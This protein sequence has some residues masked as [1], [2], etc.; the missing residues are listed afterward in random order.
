MT[1]QVV[2]GFVDGARAFVRRAIGVEL[3]GSDTSLAFVDHYLEKT[4]TPDLK[5]DVLA[6]VAPALGAYFGEVA[7]ARFGGSWVIESEAE[8][9][10]WRVELE[11]AEL[12]F[13]PVG[14]AAEALARDEVPGYDAS[15]STRP[16]WMEPLAEALS[17]SP[18]VDEAYYYSLTGRLETIEHAIQI[19]LELKRREQEEKN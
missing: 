13:F 14:L 7:I 2:Q 3:D 18:P 19:L 9:A 6:L 1:P 4:R 10:G 11:A 16:A 8:P 17:A 15:L 5:P 12:R